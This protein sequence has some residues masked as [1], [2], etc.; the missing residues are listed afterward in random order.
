MPPEF[1]FFA[2]RA[3]EFQKQLTD[4]MKQTTRNQVPIT[5]Q[6]ELTLPLPPL[7]DQRRIAAELA[8]QL[9]GVERLRLGLEEQLAAIEALPAALL[10]RAFSGEF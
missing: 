5:R 4:A 1:L 6:R 7:A 9:A 2:L 10:R 3:E 8:E